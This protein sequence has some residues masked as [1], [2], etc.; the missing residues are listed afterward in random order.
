M[1][2]LLKRVSVRPVHFSVFGCHCLRY[3]DD[4]RD[5]VQV[6]CRSAFSL[7]KPDCRTTTHLLQLEYLF[8]D[9]LPMLRQ[10]VTLLRIAQVGADFLEIELA[11]GR[12][13]SESAEF[14][15]SIQQ[16]RKEGVQGKR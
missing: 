10:E 5:D 12:A 7:S 2:Q 1:H 3:E 16:G 6:A 9:S 13:P 11:H 8:D 15:R 14:L 4:T